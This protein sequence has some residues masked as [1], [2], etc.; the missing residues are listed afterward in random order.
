M[1]IPFFFIAD[2]ENFGAEELEEK[3]TSRPLPVF[4][5]AA[6]AEVGTS[7]AES[8][9]RPDGW[10]LGAGFAGDVWGEV[11]GVGRPVN[12]WPPED[13][14]DDSNIDFV[15]NG[16]SLS[17][18]DILCK[19][20]GLTPSSGEAGGLKSP[21]GPIRLVDLRKAGLRGLRGSS[22]SCRSGLEIFTKLCR[23]EDEFRFIP[24]G[25]GPKSV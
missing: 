18:I 11:G 22:T 3:S 20:G 25:E 8:A 4:A 9:H 17:S 21:L 14:G 15:F 19:G 6:E 23:Y 12:R 2:R 13:Q 5:L 10:R 16:R 7:F 1:T 24:G